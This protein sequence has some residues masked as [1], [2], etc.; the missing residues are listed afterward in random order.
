MLVSELLNEGYKE[1]QSEFSLV[2]GEEVAKEII[3]KYQELVDKNQVHGSERNIDYWRKQGWD[4]FKVF[5]TGQSSKATK[6]SIKRKKAPGKSIVV[7]E[8]KEWLIVIPI[9]KDASCYHGKHTSWCTAIPQSHHFQDYVSKGILLIYCLRED[10]SKWAIASYPNGEYELF[11]QEDDTI[12]QDDF[13]YDTGL[14]L[15]QVISQAKA[16]PE[17]EVK[18]KLAQAIESRQNELR[19]SGVNNIPRDPNIEAQLVLIG[20]VTLV[21]KYFLTVERKTI[22]EVSSQLR[23]MLLATDPERLNDIVKATKQEQHQ[24]VANNW[25]AIQYVKNPSHELQELTIP[26]LN[27]SY[28]AYASFLRYCGYDTSPRVQL[29]AVRDNYENIQYIANPSEQVK[30]FVREH[31][32]NLEH[33]INDPR[34]YLEYK[35]KDL[36]DLLQYRQIEV[37]K[38]Q[39]FLDELDL[40]LDTLNPE[41]RAIFQRMIDDR[42]SEL[43]QAKDKYNQTAKEI[44]PYRDWLAKLPI[45][46]SQELTRIKQLIGIHKC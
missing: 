18:R 6:T 29:A 9:D 20:D 40:D 43:E 2:A 27:S 37:I 23:Q 42:K 4:L 21:F 14:D 36:S 39:K 11:N 3:S 7:S 34:R 26:Q 31:A 22:N 17:L 24:A 38:A 35:I 15:E 30:S 46:E 41:Q 45:R 28:N 25:R 44:K 16:S 33:L 12:S 10:G 13:E 5:V 19:S 8:D 1:A 32:P